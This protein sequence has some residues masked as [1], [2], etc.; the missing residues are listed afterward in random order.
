M[1]LYEQRNEASM[2]LFIS[3]CWTITGTN[4]L[5]YVFKKKKE[6]TDMWDMVNIFPWHVVN[7]KMAW[8]ICL[9]DHIWNELPVSRLAD[10]SRVF[11]LESECFPGWQTQDCLCKSWLTFQ[12]HKHVVMRY[13]LCEFARL[14][15][16]W[17]CLNSKIILGHISE[18]S[19]SN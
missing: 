13:L 9:S 16:S 8:I 1:F 5:C 3:C 12:I 2:S 14:L 18:W 11:W 19:G 17:V 7:E 10:I 6:K 15:A 4:K